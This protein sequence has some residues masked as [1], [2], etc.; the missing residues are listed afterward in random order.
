MVSGMRSIGNRERR[1]VNL[2]NLSLIH[3]N[4]SIITKVR[5]Q[6]TEKKTDNGLV[7]IHM[8]RQV[9]KIFFKYVGKF[10]NVTVS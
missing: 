8:N 10:L 7:D 4:Q 2:N 6:N 3:W 1:I 5:T 9:S